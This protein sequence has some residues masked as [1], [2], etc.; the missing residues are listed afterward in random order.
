MTTQQIE[1]KARQ[2]ATQ[3]KWEPEAAITFIT[4]LLTDINMHT[5]CTRFHQILAEEEAKEIVNEDNFRK[6]WD[7]YE[8]AS[9]Q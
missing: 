4:E 5:V 1:A 3:T 9:A 2:F 8:G 7:N 6:A